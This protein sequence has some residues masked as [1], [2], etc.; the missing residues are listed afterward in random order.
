MVND[1]HPVGQHGNSRDPRRANSLQRATMMK[2]PVS[3][4]HLR[5]RRPLWGVLLTLAVVAAIV[6]GCGDS[7]WR[8]IAAADGGFRILMRGEPQVEVRNLDT[9]IGKI[10]GNWY[11]LEGKDSVFGVGYADYPVQVV[12]ATPPQTMFT[13]VREGWLKR[14][15]GRLEG[16]ATDIKLDDK[17]SGMEFTARGKLEG[18]DAWMRGRFYLVD[19]RLYQ[20]V[21]FGNKE[22]IPTTDIRKFMGSFKVAKPNDVATVKIDAAPERKQR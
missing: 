21:V 9:P 2:N 11:S 17:W 13:I 18:R 20:L 14:I 19:N 12:Q 1:Y 4:G 16:D 7:S 22:A 5:A 6:A 15:E 8:E 10:A 3:A